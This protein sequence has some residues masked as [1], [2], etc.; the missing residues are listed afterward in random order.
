MTDPFVHPYIP[1]TAPESR[2][3]MLAAVGAA[4]VDE[5]YADVP[6]DL[7]LDRPLD[8]PEPLV[9]EQD[10]VRHVEGLLAKNV[11]TRQRLSFLGAGT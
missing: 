9:A 8:L 11:S 1:N 3:A 5:F 4:S 6:A 2:A 10:L 7:R